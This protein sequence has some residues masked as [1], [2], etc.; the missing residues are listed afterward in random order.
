MNN[1]TYMQ[2]SHVLIDQQPWLKHSGEYDE[3]ALPHPYT[4]CIHITRMAAPSPDLGRDMQHC[5]SA[6]LVPGW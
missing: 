5:H 1:S 4:D 6:V 3:R 2:T